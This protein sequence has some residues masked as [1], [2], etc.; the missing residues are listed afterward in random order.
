[1]GKDY[2]GV[3]GVAKDASEDEIKKA[4]R[5]MALRFHPDKNKESDAEEKFKEI[6]EAYEVLSDKDKR[7]VYDR[8]GEE[9]LRRG[10]GGGGGGPTSGPTYTRHF[11]FHP[12]DP[13]D[14]FRTFFGGHD[15][16]SDPFGDP[17]GSIFGG[18]PGHQQLHAHHHHGHAA[19]IFNSHPFFSSSSLGGGS[20]FDD[21]TD[22]GGSSSTTT[23]YQT[24]DGG[25]VHIT[26]TV[27]TIYIAQIVTGVD[28]PT[29]K[30][31]MA[32]A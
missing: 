15:P 2:Y 28:K 4:Y 27:G 6:G 19:R 9:G 12:M 26:R 31:P 22:M 14:L 5:K 18:M 17:F 10:G 13:F 25:T 21:M 8:Y 11:S 32:M 16:F 30:G 23:T 1:M 20:V 7:E 24:G 3:L 29:G